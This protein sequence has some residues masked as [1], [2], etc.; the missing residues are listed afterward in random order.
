MLYLMKIF[1]EKQGSEKMRFEGICPRCRSEINIDVTQI[2][3]D[4][5]HKSE[6]HLDTCQTSEQTSM[7]VCYAYGPSYGI[8]EEYTGDESDEIIVQCPICNTIV[9]ARKVF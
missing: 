7:D 4:V 5:V 6:S 1:G 9:Q 8:E 3:T 2:N